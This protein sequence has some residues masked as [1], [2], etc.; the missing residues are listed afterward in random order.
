MIKI[1][2]HNCCGYVFKRRKYFVLSYSKTDGKLLFYGNPEFKF[3]K[4]STLLSIPKSDLD[5]N[6]Y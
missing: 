3:K 2:S 5:E 1:Y 6:L 4:S